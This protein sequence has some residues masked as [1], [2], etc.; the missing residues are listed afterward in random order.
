MRSEVTKLQDV[1]GGAHD[2]HEVI[3]NIQYCPVDADE[4]LR[5]ASENSERSLEKVGKA[6][7]RIAEMQVKLTEA[8]AQQLLIIS[9]S[10]M[11]ETQGGA[12]IV[13]AEC[14]DKEKDFNQGMNLIMELFER[15]LGS[16]RAVAVGTEERDHNDV[17]HLERPLTDLDH[18]LCGDRL[19]DEPLDRDLDASGQQVGAEVV[20]GVPWSCAMSSMQTGTTSVR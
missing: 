5:A 4:E 15:G 18:V 10:D 14:W 11:A 13:D 2:A 16:M 12:H 8:H 17:T 1:V 6:R 9:T 19:D 7:S 3:R 20:L